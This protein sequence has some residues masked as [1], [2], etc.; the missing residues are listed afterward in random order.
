MCGGAQNT[1]G[2]TSLLLLN[3]TPCK[4]GARKIIHVLHI[5]SYRC[6]AGNTDNN[7][8]TASTV[9]IEYNIKYL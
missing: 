5:I 8:S 9:F 2:E 7:T 4:S 1:C 3:T 6:I